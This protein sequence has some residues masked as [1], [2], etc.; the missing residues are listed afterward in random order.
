M[1][2][3]A[4]PLHVVGTS[5]YVSTCT[6]CMQAIILYCICCNVCAARKFSEQQS[7]I[8]GL[9]TYKLQVRVR[10]M[11]VYCTISTAC[12]APWPWKS[13][14]FLR[15]LFHWVAPHETNITHHHKMSIY[16]PTHSQSFYQKNQNIL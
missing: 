3:H 6:C 4:L 9:T 16:S 15:Y 11:N 12:G 14:L 2:R 7:T 8:V 10:T 1:A 5:T 13:T